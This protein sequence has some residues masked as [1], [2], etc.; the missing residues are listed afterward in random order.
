VY[1]KKGRNATIKNNEELF[2]DYGEQYR[3]NPISLGSITHCG[4]KLKKFKDSYL[5]EYD[6]YLHDT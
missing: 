6:S 1:D 5:I 2:A 3:F 4:E